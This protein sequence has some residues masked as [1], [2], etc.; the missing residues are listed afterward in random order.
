MSTGTYQA[1]AVIVTSR[2]IAHTVIEL[3]QYVAWIVE[4]II[5]NGLV[6]MAFSGDCFL[7][8]NNE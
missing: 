7:E 8:E 4:Q 2:P 6:K 3:K 1:E 5:I